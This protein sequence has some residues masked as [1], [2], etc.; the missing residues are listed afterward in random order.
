MEREE[1]IQFLKDN[2]KI[3]LSVEDDWESKEVCVRLYL[4]DE[5]ISDDFTY[6]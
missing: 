6:V 4:G 5:I 1:L 2:L 3:E